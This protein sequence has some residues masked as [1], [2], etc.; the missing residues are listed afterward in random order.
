M[1]TSN[2]R[3]WTGRVLSGIPA[4]FMLWDAA[5]KIVVNHYVTESMTRLGWPA[6]EVQ[7]GVT[8]LACVLLYLA[9]RTRLLGAVLLTAWLGGAVATHVRIGDPF[10]FPIITGVFVWAGLLLR[11]AALAQLMLGS[12]TPPRSESRPVLE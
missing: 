10:Y 2:K 9:T 12:S 6:L 4:V 3:L 7:L 1:E 11:D 5:M 8:E